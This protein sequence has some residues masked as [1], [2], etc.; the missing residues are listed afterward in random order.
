MWTVVL[1][2]IAYFWLGEGLDQSAAPYWDEGFYITDARRFLAGTPL[3]NPE[4]PPLGKWLIG[5]SI[6]VF[7]D[8][9]LG[10]RMPSLLAITASITTLPLWLERLGLLGRQ[11][12]RWLLFLPSLF[13]LT[14]PLIFTTARVATL[15]AMLTAFYVNAA[16]ALAW[17]HVAPSSEQARRARWLAGTLTGLAL[18]TKWTALTLLP[19][20]LVPCVRV[21]GKN[22]HVDGAAMRQLF[23][24][25]GLTYLGSFALPGATHF[26]LHAFPQIEGPL[27]ADLP[28]PARVVLL[29]WRM[30]RYHTF[31]FQNDMR[32]AWWEWL[33]ARQ[34]VWY[35]VRVEGNE[36]RAIVAYGNP[37][38]WTLSA[39]ALGGAAV[40]AWRVRDRA[41]ALVACFAFAQL[42]LWAVVPRMTFL[43]YMS[44]IIPFGAV[45]GAALLARWRATSAADASRRVPV[46]ATFLL[47]LAAAWQLHTLA[48]A[49]GDPMSM[50][51]L[52]SHASGPWAPF[53]FHDAMPL[54]RVL[55][56]VRST[57]FGAARIVD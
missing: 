45:A 33:I 26:D 43:Y 14:D 48:L 46:A 12:P 49:R 36:V 55:E 22:V 53:L 7:G 40:A 28:W 2:V 6:R 56:I 20:C 47:V 42:A 17:S 41:L 50:A 1:G 18:G 34:A 15:D 27:D 11:P 21:D 24:P 19:F 4:H 57:G 32:S 35:S 44:S 29:H 9:A 51:A 39:L 3:L 16:L 52:E 23:I 38:T 30:V 10:W 5:L 8:D 13:L 25:L 54:P 37:L 31:Y